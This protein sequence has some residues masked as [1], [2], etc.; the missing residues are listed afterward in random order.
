MGLPN[1]LVTDDYYMRHPGVVTAEDD[2]MLS[3]VNR[4]VSHE[5]PWDVAAE[6]WV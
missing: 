6:G 5:L 1:I 4:V 3:Q 2:K